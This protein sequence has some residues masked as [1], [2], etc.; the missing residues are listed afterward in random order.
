MDGWLTSR[1]TAVL[2]DIQGTPIWPSV[3][4]GRALAGKSWQDHAAGM[5]V[6]ENIRQFKA[7]D[8]AGDTSRKITWAWVPA[9]LHTGTVADIS[10]RGT[11]V[12][13]VRDIRPAG[14][15]VR[16]VREDAVR[17]IRILQAAI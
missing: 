8:E 7:A 12:G 2:D 14:E 5:P 4:D 17:R 10:F 6:D 9:C 1:R 16:E 15:I 13:L 3:Y 11:G